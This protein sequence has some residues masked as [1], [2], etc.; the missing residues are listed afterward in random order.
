MEKNI[1]KLKVAV[2]LGGDSP[3]RDVSL[4]SGGEIIKA[5]RGRGHEVFPVDSAR[6]DGKYREGEN[7]GIDTEPPEEVPRVDSAE[8]LGWL[9]GE[10]TGRADLLF[11]ALHG[12]AGE[13]GTVQALLETAGVVYTGAGILGSAIAMNKD[14]SKALMS[15]AGVQTAEHIL[16]SCRQGAADKEIEKRIGEGI[17]FPV[18]VK[19]NSQG[20]SV[21]FSFVEKASELDGALK[22]GAEFGDKLIIERYIPGRELTVA[23][24]GGEAFPPVEIIPEG[25][26]Y[27]YKCKYTKGSSEY[28]V[29]AEIEPACAESLKTQA[30]IAYNTLLC[31][32]YAR[33]DF[34][35]DSE[36]GIFCLELNTLPGMTQLSLVPMA[37]GQAGIP[38]DMLIEKICL[39]ALERSGKK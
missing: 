34:R 38:F 20:S 27:N 36:S 21:G 32:D 13:D 5:L 4:A 9:R 8:S 2:L 35:V 23:V 37:A 26:F 12:G 16:Y 31:R 3:E 25:G 33:V 1:R 28:V 10:W 7:S 14:L 39:L 11:N 15:Q 24:V 6:P 22:K 19:P 17:G 29:P 30:L 18:V